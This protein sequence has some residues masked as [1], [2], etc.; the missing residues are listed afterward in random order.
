MPGKVFTILIACASVCG[1]NAQ[2]A[3]QRLE[4]FQCYPILEVEP[5]I[6]TEV[7]LLDQ[8][9][10]DGAFETVKVRRAV[11]FCNPT[12]KIHKRSAFGVH[13]IRQHL[14]L[15]PTFPQSGPRRVVTIRNQF[16]HQKLLVREPVALA[17]P[18]QKL[19][20]GLAPHDFPAGLDHFRCYS[21]TGDPL[22]GDNARVGLSD[23]FVLDVHKHLVF[24]PVS[25]CNPAAKIDPS[26]QLFPIENEAAHLTC[27]A[28]TRIRFEGAAVV[29]N[30]F[31]DQ[32]LRLGPADTLC[33]PTEKLEVALIADFDVAAPG[34][35][36][37]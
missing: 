29:S 17:V 20:G 37:D 10:A 33:V 11:R 23:Q 21:A 24:E 13:D 35:G 26:G 28:M 6:A 34:E 9:N 12:R 14:T 22:R 31:D 36:R 32:F 7:G 8:F 3:P 1:L 18:T 2:N 16:G 27:Y 5:E 30:Q 25:F 15:Y 4:H 19:Q